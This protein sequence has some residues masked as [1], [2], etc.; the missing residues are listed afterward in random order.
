MKNAIKVIVLLCAF[1]LCAA[2][3]QFG[4]AVLD[5]LNAMGSIRPT[6]NASGAMT[7]FMIFLEAEVSQSGLTLKI[8]QSNYMEYGV[9]SMVMDVGTE[10]GYM[11]F[12][13]L[14]YDWT[15]TT[16]DSYVV[17]IGKMENV[18]LGYAAQ[19]RYINPN[20]QYYG[21]IELYLSAD[22][23]L[24]LRNSAIDIDGDS[25]IV[26]AIPEPSS[27]LL[28]LLGAA[29]LALRRIYRRGFAQCTN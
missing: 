17:S 20:V 19:D 28:V 14:V 18:Y 21:W 25:I 26:G 3:V 15:Q 1:R 12:G 23:V 29:G 2:A 22:N 8:Y 24:S 16:S 27:G 10:C 11:S 7:D 13:T 5:D 6:A 4:T 9:E